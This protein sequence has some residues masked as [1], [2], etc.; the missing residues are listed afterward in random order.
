MFATVFMIPSSTLFLLFGCWLTGALL[1][2][3]L[4][5]ANHRRLNHTDHHGHHS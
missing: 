3:S 4:F 5:V 1:I 2:A